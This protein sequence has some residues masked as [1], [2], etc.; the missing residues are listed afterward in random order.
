MK[1]L[2]AKK[3]KKKIESHQDWVVCPGSQ[4]LLV[5]EDKERLG[6]WPQ[7]PVSSPLRSS[8]PYL[9]QKCCLLTGRKT[10]QH[11][12]FETSTGWPSL[13]VYTTGIMKPNWKEKWTRFGSQQ[14]K[15]CSSWEKRHVCKCGCGSDKIVFGYMWH[16]GGWGRIGCSHG[17]IC[18][19]KG[20]AMRKVTRR[21][22]EGDS[23]RSQFIFTLNMSK[24][25]LQS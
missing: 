1:I 6:P 20:S 7:T 14:K 8:M 4:S 15:G 16:V 17:L 11:D 3:K 9:I 22:A 12:A 10:N 2:R 21:E 24:S 5:V 23:V 25:S 19:S 18:Y 13:A